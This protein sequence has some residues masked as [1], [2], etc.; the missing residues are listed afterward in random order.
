[1][2]ERACGMCGREGSLQSQSLNLP[3]LK[4]TAGLLPL[5]LKVNA[6]SALYN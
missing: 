2:D 1:M 6:H 4:R 5:V 3:L